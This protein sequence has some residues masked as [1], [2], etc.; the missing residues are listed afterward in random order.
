MYVATTQE[1]HHTIKTTVYPD[2]MYR[3]NNHTFSSGTTIFMD[4]EAYLSMDIIDT[5]GMN[6]AAKVARFDNNYGFILYAFKMQQ[7]CRSVR[8]N[9]KSSINWADGIKC[10]TVDKIYMEHCYEY[11]LDEKKT[12]IDHTA[13]QK[14]IA[15]D[16]VALLEAQK[17][18]SSAVVNYAALLIGL[19]KEGRTITA[20]YGIKDIFESIWIQYHNNVIVS[21]DDKGM[22]NILEYLHPDIINVITNNLISRKDWDKLH[23]ILHKYNIYHKV[24]D[25]LLSKKIELPEQYIIIWYQRIPHIKR[26]AIRNALIV[27]YGVGI[28]NKLKIHP[29]SKLRCQ[30]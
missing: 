12:S 30:L 16:V 1:P 10:F 14:Y 18:C 6:I 25:Y 7:L 5:G 27:Q 2:F 13:A 4:D 8:Y 9:I 22:K 20:S 11:F 26:T 17:I 29:P 21:C 19:R 15:S 23:I 24:L 28:L 3:I